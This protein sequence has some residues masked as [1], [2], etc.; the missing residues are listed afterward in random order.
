[1][2]AARRRRRRASSDVRRRREPKR[3]LRQLGG[4][5]RRAAGVRRPRGV[6]EDRGD[7]AIGLGRGEREVARS[8]LG[9]RDDRRRAVRAAT[10]GATGVWRA[11]TA[12]P[13]SG[14]VNRR[15]SPSSSRIRASSASAR[16]ASAA[17][18]D[19]GFH[20]GDGRIGER[21]DSARDLERRGAEAVEARVQELVEVGGNRE[22]LAGSERA[23]SALERA[24]RA[25]ARRRGCRCEVSQSLISVG[26]GNVASRRARRSSWVA[27]RL[28]PPT[29]TVRSRSSGTARRS[30][31]GTSPRTA[32]RAATGSRSSRASA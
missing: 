17:A 19:G 32:S 29:S 2:S 26:R 14:W 10:G 11:A 9:G 23:A 1:M 20:E 22:L 21:R 25:R 15:R 31:S 30:H 18:T 8:F 13:S 4:R 7:L 5:R 27:P 24:L 3:L 16:P 12:D 28:R 6:L